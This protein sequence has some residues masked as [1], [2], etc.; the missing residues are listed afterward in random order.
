MRLLTSL[1]FL[2]T[3]AISTPASANHKKIILLETMPVPVVLEHSQELV[4]AFSE[5]SARSDYEISVE[6]LSAEGSKERAVKLLKESL[7]KES[8]DLVVTVA[9]LASQAAVEVFAGTDIPILFCVVSDPVGSGIVKQIG[10]AN[11]GNVSGIVSSQQRDTKI[12]MVQRILDASGHEGPVKIGV[13][14][15]DYPSAI[16]DLKAFQAIADSSSLITFVPYL[17][18]Y[19]PVPAGLPSML[20]KMRI[21]LDTLKGKVD[22]LWQTSGPLGELEVSTQILLDSGIPLIQGNTP[23][24]VEMGA[25]T[26]VLGDT[27]DTAKQ[28][29]ERTALILQG[30]DVGTLPVVLPRQFKLYINMNAAEKHG[31]TVP[32]HLLLI[33]GENLIY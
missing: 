25:V 10:V 1:F 27:T 17:F 11:H 4:N 22:F 5:L 33:A 24:A 31:L 8:P 13:V 16:G 29:V 2:G 28:I 7:A 9:T 15:S 14:S 18:P 12:E 19:E 3:L 32:S 30:A 20:E 6:I 23:K 26:A 21:G